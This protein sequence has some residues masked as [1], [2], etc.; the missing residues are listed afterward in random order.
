MF[1]R[2]IS[3]R[4]IKVSINNYKLYELLKLNIRRKKALKID[5]LMIAP[6]KFL[7]RFGETRNEHIYYVVDGIGKIEFIDFEEKPFFIEPYSLI[8]IPYAVKH[9]IINEG[10]AILHIIDFILMEF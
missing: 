4:A 9:R 8:Y 6:E 10:S 1:P 5:S 2:K 3:N 7:E